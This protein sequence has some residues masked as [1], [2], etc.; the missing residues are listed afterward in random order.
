MILRVDF[1]P[2]VWHRLIS[3]NRRGV[4]KVPRRRR[5]R[6]NAIYHHIWKLVGKRSL[7]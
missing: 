3:F 1:I 7:I 5:S 6:A 4:K 2:A